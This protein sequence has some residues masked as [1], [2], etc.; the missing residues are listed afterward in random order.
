MIEVLGPNHRVDACVRHDRR[1]TLGEIGPRGQADSG[2]R[3]R[4][5]TISQRDEDRKG[6]AAPG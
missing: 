6:E 3:Q 2:R 4:I 1:S 5:S